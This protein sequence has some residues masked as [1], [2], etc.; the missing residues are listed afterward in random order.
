MAARSMT[1]LNDIVIFVKVAQFESI[2]KAAR[3]L[4]MSISTASRRLSVLESAL[5]ASLVQ[6]S[7]RRVTLTPQ[8]REY[9][10]QCRQPLTLLEE[11]ERVLTQ[12]QRKPDGILRLTVPMILGQDAFLEFLS[13]FS[14]RHS[15]IRIDL[16]I[17]NQ[18]LD[19]VA[20][21]IDL[22]IRFGA[23]RESRLVASRLGKWIRYVV[24][25]PDYLHGRK[26]PVEPYDLK[27]HDC[28]VLNARNNEADWD[29]SNGRRSVRV[30]VSGVMASHDCRSVTGFVRRGHGLGLLPSKD[31]EEALGRGDLVRLL[32]RWASP[33]IPVFAVYPSRKFLPLRVSAFLQA[34]ARWNSPLWTRD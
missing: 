28:V 24:A 34:L 6:R 18:F 25:S 9:F 8:G 23:L 7:T 4:G 12:A 17:T 30:R 15:G 10:T 1:D 29:L 27:S 2:S 22:A 26:V 16:V 11:A 13:Q 31:C 3:S 14:R 20:D 21:N 5:G 33:A 32:P 19:L